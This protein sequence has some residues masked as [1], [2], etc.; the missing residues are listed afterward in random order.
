LPI[1]LPG[2]VRPGIQDIFIDHPT[3]PADLVDP[4]ARAESPVVEGPV[5]EGPVVQGTA[6]A[7]SPRVGFACRWDE[8][9]ERTW[10]YTPW[11]LRAALRL[12]TDTTDVGVQLSCAARTAL[13]AIHVRPIQGRLGTMWTTSHLTDAYYRRLL[14]RGLSETAARRCDAVLTMQDFGAAVPVPY[15]AYQDITCDASIAATRGGLEA[16]A[17]LRSMSPSILSRWRERQL[18][19][20]EQATGIIAMSRWFAR[21]LVELTGV[22]PEKVHVVH[23]GISAVPT[24]PDGR[25]HRELGLRPRERA[26]PRRRLLFVGRQYKRTDFHRKGGDLVVG[27]LAILRRQC[28]PRITLTVVGPDTWPLPGNVPDGVRLLG[29]LPPSQV[30][31]LYADHDLL[32]MPSRMEPFGIVFAEALAH[33]LPCVAR[34]AYAMPE[35]ITPGVSGALIAAD[36]ADELADVVAA[37]LADDALYET[38]RER[39]PKMASYFSWDRSAREITQII[40][41]TLR[42]LG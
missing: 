13:K 23:P 28:D 12:V 33:G 26:V 29:S 17:A 9:P 40:A 42:R 19:V 10:S 14:Q 18:A 25:A 8:V 11:N 30:A 5:V 27:A 37:A 4:L 20:Y 24:A 3:R 39:A 2:T 34:D 15:F 31:A 16:Y 36:D 38:C 21:S 41:G 32:V 6:V 22:A 1:G 35:I 7:G